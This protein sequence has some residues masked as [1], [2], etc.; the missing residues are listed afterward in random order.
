MA[1][2]DGRVVYRVIIDDSNVQSDMQRT[3][4]TVE[5]STSNLKSKAKAGAL[6]IGGGILGTVTAIG[7][8]AVKSAN[9]MDKAM[10]QFLASTG[11]GT[12]EA[13]RYQEVMESIYTNNYGESFEDIAEKMGLVTQQMGELSD[14]ELK[15]VT[16]QAYLLQDTF[17]MDFKESIRGVDAL[18]KQFGVSSEEAFELMAQGAQA[19]LNQNDD[20]ADQLAE[21]SVYYKQLGFDAEDALNI[22][23][24]GT[25]NGAYQLDYINDAMKE[26]GIRSKD[27]SV[28]TETAFQKLGLD[29]QKYF[30]VFAKGGGNTGEYFDEVVSLLSQVESDVERNSIGVALFGT[31]FEDLGEDAVLAMTKFGN[32]IDS[33]KNKLGEMEAVKYGSLEEMLEGLKRSL[34]PILIDLGQ[35]LI[36]IIK[37]LAE[38]L[39]PVVEQL[40]P[41]FSDVLLALI[42]PLGD[43]IDA[44]LPPLIELFEMLIPPLLEIIEALMPVLID[45][46][47]ALAP[48]LIDVANAL[49]PVIDFVVAL[50]PIIV[51]LIEIGIIPLIDVI[52]KL[53]GYGLDLLTY[54]L[55]VLKETFLAVFQSIVTIVQDNINT[56]TAI[57]NKMIEFIKNVFAGNWGEAWKNIMEIMK[58]Y[59]E[60]IGKYFKNILNGVIDSINGFLKGLNGIKIPDWV[61]KIGGGTF[62]VPLIPRLAKGGLAMGETLAVVGDNPNASIDPEVIAPLSKLKAM[63]GID[64]NSGVGMSKVIYNNVTVTGNTINDDNIDSIGDDFMRKLKREGI[65]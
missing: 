2:E 57:L 58:L 40:M 35:K 29:A 34:A 63:L 33:T 44:L 62:S 26:F 11:K 22:M 19:G 25:K 30:E 18:V 65:Y 17:D 64:I 46:V 50:I 43:L 15:R 61:P 56:V 51:E 12:E 10:N 23:L 53:I 4:N 41:V 27:M 42:P 38:R 48:L 49:I 59:F 20:L 47:L 32:T 13:E 9:D 37:L 60:G 7:V 54:A 28:S 6:A 8:G 21:Y 5:K 52:S 16:E 36:P 14:D 55:G 3:E 24:E 31:K 45:L 39:F 1:R